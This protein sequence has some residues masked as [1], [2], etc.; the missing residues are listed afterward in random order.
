MPPSPACAASSALA[1]SLYQTVQADPSAAHDVRLQA[2]LGVALVAFAQAKLGTAD[3][4]LSLVLPQSLAAGDSLSV[5]RALITLATIRGRTLGGDTALAL[6]RRGLTFVPRADERS[7]ALA[8]C[9]YALLLTQT[10]LG[11]SVAPVVRRGLDL[12]RRGGTR[13]AEGNCYQ[14]LG[15]GW[16]RQG[17]PDSAIVA[18]GL[19]AQALRDGHDVASA[20]AALQWQGYVLRLVGELGQAQVVLAEALRIADST[21]SESVRGWSLLNLGFVH[22][23]VGD[24]AQAARDFALAEESMARQGDRWGLATVR[25]AEINAALLQGDTARARVRTEEVTREME[26]LGNPSFRSLA[27]V[28]ATTLARLQ[29]DWP[30]AETTARDLL[31][32]QRLPGAGWGGVSADY[33]AA[34]IPLEAGQWREAER[35]LA[36]MTVRQGEHWLD[37]AVLARQAETDARLG[38]IDSAEARM[39]RA[40]TALDAWRASLTTREL[41]LGVLQVPFDMADPDL[42]VATVIAL[43]AGAGRTKAAFELA[44]SRRARGL[45]DAV[46]RRQALQDAARAPAT[47]VVMAGSRSAR[48]IQ[49]VLGPGEAVV[50]FVTGQRDEPTTAFVVT[51]DALTAVLLA[52]ADTLGPLI[53]RFRGLLEASAPDQALAVRLGGLVMA[54][55]AALLPKGTTRIFI[56]PDGPLNRLAFDAVML[57]GHRMVERYETALLPSASILPVLRQR[58][59]V[60][61]ANGVLAFGVPD[62]PAGTEAAWLELPSLPEAIPEARLAAGAARRS[63]LLTGSEG[64]EAALRREATGDYSVLHLAAHAVVDEQVSARTALL[65]APGDGDDGV[66]GLA[67]VE[68]MGVGAELVVLSACRTAGGAILSGEG[69][70]GLTSAFLGAGARAVIATAWLASDSVAAGEMKPF[71]TELGKGMPAGE[72]L[73]RMKLAGLAAGAPPSAWALFTLSGDPTVALDAPAPG[74]VKWWHLALLAPLGYFVSRRGLKALSTTRPSRSDA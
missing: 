19:G 31:I 33:V 1:D 11:D 74:P 51:H 40:G 65:L 30:R 41:R 63:R 4:A 38:Q 73:R 61:H 58:K 43:L 35:R 53:R 16:I 15:R 27:L 9:A 59:H 54:P 60:P 10:A 36:K 64:S 47:G 44:E 25:I 22:A 13:L 69:V 23:D 66:V 20:A 12:S 21:N 42:G 70:L 17:K 45:L 28:N 2:R 67:D 5:A 7:A 50:S 24:R 34:V 32:S 52:P 37:Y 56:S 14:A 49:Q 71:Y 57:D 46:V 18:F 6:A 8:L 29:R 72:A 39:G 48:E 26:A 3:S 68:A 62:A 55:V